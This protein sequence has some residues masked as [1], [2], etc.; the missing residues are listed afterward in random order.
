MCTVEHITALYRRRR[1]ERGPGWEIA[2]LATSQGPTYLKMSGFKQVMWRAY[3]PSF[4]TKMPSN[5]CGGAYDF[6]LFG[7][8][9]V[10]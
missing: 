6:D 1:P 3:S 2:T 7:L 4:I 5:W 8:R 9:A 10:Q